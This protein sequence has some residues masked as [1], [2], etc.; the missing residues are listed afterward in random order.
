VTLD[1]PLPRGLWKLVRRK[2]TPVKAT[3]TVYM[4]SI[5]RLELNFGAWKTIV[6]DSNVPVDERTTR[7][8]YIQMRS[9]FTGSWADAD[10]R[11]RMRKIFLEDQRTV[12]AQRPELLP[13]D[14]AAELSIKSDG[15]GVA[16]RK[17]RKKYVDMGWQIDDHLI[18][19]QINGRSA[20]VIPSPA[21]R[22]V[23]E[24]EKS[25]VIPEAPVI[26]LRRRA[27]SE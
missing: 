23:P 22:E 8:L 4:P 3:V 17:L 24:L 20:V 12:E 15:L 10:A 14:L 19:S 26:E 11:R 2:R 1:P 21:R 13:Y 7:T 18:R 16:Y 27:S 6:F 5:S 25:W 9:F